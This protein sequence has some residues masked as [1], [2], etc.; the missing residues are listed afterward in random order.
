MTKA[1]LDTNII[2]SSV[3]WEGKPYEV[4]RKGIRGEFNIVIS[5]EIL[6][7]TADRLR[8]KFQLPEE[9]IQEL[10]DILLTYSQIIQP[11][12]TFDVVRDKK[13][14]KIIECAFDGQADYIVTG[15]PDLLILKEFRGIKIVKAGE[16]LE[17]IYHE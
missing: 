12:S 2:I 15:D 11:V 16:F 1:V 14:N 13:D 10:M 5:P 7:E 9:A 3:F 4:V 8:N 6:D 17:K